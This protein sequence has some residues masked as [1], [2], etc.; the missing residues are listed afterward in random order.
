MEFKKLWTRDFVLVVLA[1]GLAFSTICVTGAVLS[2]YIVRQF[3]GGAVQVGLISSLMTLSTF[4]FRPFTGYLVDR[5]GRKWTL[6]AALILDALIS[7][8]LLLP[9]GLVGL[10]ILR[11]LIGFPFALFSTGLNTLTADLIPEERR[12]EGL[13]ISSIVTTISGQVLA[14]ILALW[15]LG[16]ANFHSVFIFAGLLAVI[17]TCLVLL[18]RT[19]DIKNGSLA[20]SFAS[21]IE[22]R[23]LWLALVMGLTFLGWPGL[24]TYGPLMAEEAGFINASPFLMAFGIGLLFSQLLGK[25]LFNLTAP[26][27][28]G[29]MALLILVSG[30]VLV[31]FVHVKLAFL[32]GG[33]LMGT[34]FGLSFA[35][36]PVMA[37]NLV[38]ADR[39]GACNATIIFGQDVGVFIGS[40]VFG[41]TARAAGNYGSSYG[42][43]GLLL[44][45][46]LAVFL[47]SALPDYQRRVESSVTD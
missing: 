47:F 13:G 42:L 33:G 43:V 20:F 39:R 24:L 2:L 27:R 30:F 18:T 40:Y 10:G 12:S 28:A 19:A 23:V 35:I 31:G 25:R 36:F 11:F 38:E 21:L 32:L 46:P 5:F 14:P 3:N 8:S 4:L 41:W 29:G 37:V 45:L 26:R 16:D 34:G 6:T 22:K 1:N 9:T 7:F 15:L 17:A 44:L